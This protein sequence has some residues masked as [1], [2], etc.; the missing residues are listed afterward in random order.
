MYVRVVLGAAG[1]QHRRFQQARFLEQAV[2]R[3]AT[4]QG[5][6]FFLEPLFS[7]DTYD[8]LPRMLDI[9]LFTV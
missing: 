3:Y 9:Q 6:I 5:A 1:I 2:Y 4:E 8:N 7:P